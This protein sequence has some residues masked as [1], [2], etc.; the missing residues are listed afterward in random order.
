MNNALRQRFRLCSCLTLL[1]V[2]GCAY[3]TA[4][5]KLAPIIPPQPAF[6]P[7]V[8]QTV[9]DFSYTLEGGKMVT[10]NFAGRLLNESILGAWKDRG[11]I[12]EARYV[13]KGAFSGKPHYNITLSGTQYGAS[14]IGLQ[15]LS[16]LT[17]FLVPYTVTQS[18]DIQYSLVDVKTG[19]KFSASVQ[20]SNKTYVELFLLFAL[21]VAQRGQTQMMERMGDHLYEQLY[22]QGAFQYPADT[23][24]SP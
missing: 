2:S 12:S 18:Y 16:G 8:E 10:S 24:A 13:E 21:P 19:K 1:L 5:T 3:T 20:E 4:G 23:P 15:V 14:S 7:S 22:R 11:Y 17:L 6:K 9:G